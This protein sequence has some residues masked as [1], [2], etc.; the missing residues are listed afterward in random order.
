VTG[1]LDRM[2]LAASVPP[3][4]AA[5][6]APAAAPGLGARQREIE[7]VLAEAWREVAGTAPADHERN[8]FDLGGSSMLMV[9]M[10]SVLEQRLAMEVPITAL[11][12]YPT[13]RQLAAYL[14]NAGRPDTK[15]PVAA[16]AQS[17]HDLRARRLAARGAAEFP[18]P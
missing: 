8:F 17:S 18:R 15:R 12:E 1:K 2:A 9:R 10:H 14:M 13:V 16:A 6:A 7:Y 5:P 4:P 3:A 11:F